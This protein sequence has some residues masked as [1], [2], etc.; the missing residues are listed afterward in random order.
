MYSNISSTASLIG[1]PTRTTILIALA[2]GQAL[3]AGELAT[4][5]G[6]SPQT[7]SAHLAKLVEGSLISVE[8]QGRHRYYKLAGPEVAQ[9]MEAIA[10]VSPPVK[11]RSLRQSSH[12]KALDYARTCYDHLAGKLGVALTE[13]LIELG[14]LRDLGE[15]YQLTDKGKQWL[16][17]FG[18]HPLPKKVNPEAVP[19]HIDWTVRKHHLAGPLAISITQR[20]IDLGWVEKG[21][22][23]RSIQLTNLGRSAIGNEFMFD[24]TTL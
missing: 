10:V 21:A 8:V 18:I 15:F 6:V 14:Y 23:R 12:K 4:L 16:R 13:A 2:D 9:V 19:L 3:T 5:S 7:A 24:P 1:D 22:I 17:E 20:L 11:V